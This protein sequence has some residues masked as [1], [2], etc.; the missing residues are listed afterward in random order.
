MK[1]N[2]IVRIKIGAVASLQL[3]LAA[4]PPASCRQEQEETR[5]GD[6]TGSCSCMQVALRQFVARRCSKFFAHAGFQ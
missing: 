5:I 1:A 4:A 3:N 2:E 6:C